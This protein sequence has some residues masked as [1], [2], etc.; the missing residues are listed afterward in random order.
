MNIVS[1][2]ELSEAHPI[3]LFKI[4]SPQI[5]V[6]RILSNILQ[7]LLPRYVI[8]VFIEVSL[9]NGIAFQRHRGNDR[10]RK[11]FIGKH[12]GVK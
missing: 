4:E 2:K 9:P 6:F 1:D 12:N 10:V 5:F 3:L 11:D 8:N 7:E